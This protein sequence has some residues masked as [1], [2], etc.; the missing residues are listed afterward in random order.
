[1]VVLPLGDAGLISFYDMS[2]PFK[3]RA[4]STE[5]FTTYVAKVLLPLFHRA[6]ASP[7]FVLLVHNEAQ[8][9]DSEVREGGDHCQLDM[10]PVKERF[11][12]RSS[13][14]LGTSRWSCARFS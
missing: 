6:V 13:R 4:V 7:K 11:L 2:N 12:L 8:V 1:M 3:D 14:R 5:V 9:V 10:S